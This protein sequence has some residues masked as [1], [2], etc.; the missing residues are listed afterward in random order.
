MT[1][2]RFDSAAP[3]AVIKLG[4]SV[5]VDPED[6]L[7]ATSAIYS[8]L[9][10]GMRVIA[11]VSAM[12]DDT[13]RLV[14][15]AGIA[16]GADPAIYARLLA[17]GE[18][19]SALLLAM[20]LERAGIACRHTSVAEAGLVTGGSPLEGEPVRL[21]R[22][23]LRRL[24]ET[25]PVVILPGFAAVDAEGRPT[26]LGRGGSDLT[27]LFVASEL[28]A[29]E[30][31][32]CKDVDGLYERDPAS[33]SPRPGRFRTAHWNTALALGGPL[34]QPRAVEFAARRQ[35]T[36]EITGPLAQ[37]GTRIGD[38][39]DTRDWGGHGRPLR[40]GV[41]GAGTV[42]G[43]VLSHLVRVP[44]QF[45]ITGI[46]VRDP[47][48]PR[49]DLP[50]ALPVT[51]NARDVLDS[52]CDVVIEL[53][54]GIEA[55]GSA[56]ASALSRGIDVITAN[57]ALL[58]ER[59]AALAELARRHGA[60][61]SGAAAVGGGM[62]A[63]E[64]VRHASCRG[65]VAR[66]TGV[67]NGTCN[68]VLDRLQEGE[69]FEAAVRSAQEAGFA[70]AD[71]SLDIDGGDAASKLAILSREAW[72]ESPSPVAR[73][74]RRLPRARSGQVIRLVARA[75]RTASGL[76]AEVRPEA[77]AP[78]TFLAGARGVGNRLEIKL[79]TGELIRA[80]GAGAGRWP[81]ALAVM[82]DLAAF[83]EAKAGRAPAAGLASAKVAAPAA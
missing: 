14:K 50:A 77:V 2:L 76:L 12:G 39:R 48:R 4:S 54:G 46:A 35:L 57:K 55:A 41:L 19:R 43:G 20:A 7:V 65:S 45:E 32:L 27:A 42:G 34:V 26:L 63:I 9:A 68:Y 1:A 21:D 79:R 62:P 16:G 5:L 31:L 47:D 83:S 38:F 67:L 66:I 75:E 58:A 59:G 61:L 17:T 81:T 36:F 64:A 56:V 71:P 70:E 10:R 51:G 29:S 74:I 28:D 11:V 80:T 44:G 82:S 22:D 60:G 33:S 3:L 13:D 37:A 69:C 40:V 8:R 15:S 52:G 30:C 73:G 53:I 23:R 18:E 72:G 6:L 25:N 78:G 24:L 49:P